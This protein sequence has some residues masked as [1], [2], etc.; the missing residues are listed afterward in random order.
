MV[1]R[2]VTVNIHFKMGV[3]M[4]GH[5]KRIKSTVLVQRPIKMVPYIMENLFSIKGMVMERW[6]FQINQH[7]KVNL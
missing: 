7:I 2:R 3:I 6:F 1:K 5:S 4:L